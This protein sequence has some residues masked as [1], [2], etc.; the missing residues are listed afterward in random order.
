LAPAAWPSRNDAAI[1]TS[2]RAG[3]RPRETVQRLVEA[4]GSLE[5]LPFAFREAHTPK[6]G[7][8]HATPSLCP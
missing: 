7:W 2:L 8:L 6:P 4:N 3:R 5:M 1:H